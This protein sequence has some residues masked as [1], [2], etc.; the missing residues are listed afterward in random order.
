MPLD[1]EAVARKLNELG[2]R[3]PCHRCG[4][5]EFVVIDN[6]TIFPMQKELPGSYPYGGFS[7]PVTL[8][9]CT[10]C[11]AITPHALGA[12]G[13]LPHQEGKENAK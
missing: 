11:G 5:K 7:I 4:G 9:A 2:A 8:V 1:K 3:M 12:L 10:K 13:M 6:Y